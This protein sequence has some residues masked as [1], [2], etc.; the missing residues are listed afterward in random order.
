MKRGIDPSLGTLI[1]R[2]WVG[3]LALI[4]L[5]GILSL[6]LP[7]QPVSSAPLSNGITVEEISSSYTFAQQLSFS[8]HATANADIVRVYL[9][10]RATSDAQALPVPVEIEPT[11]DLSVTH[12]LDLRR[13]PLQPFATAIYWWHILDADGN[14][15][16]TEAQQFKYMDDRFQWQ[17]LSDDTGAGTT[18]HWIDGQGDIVFGQAALDIA[19][20][21]LKEIN[22][23]LRAPT[24]QPIDIYIYDGQPN[25]RAA[26]VLTGREWVGGQAHPELGIVV[27]AVPFE[28]GYTTRMKRDIPHEITHLLVYRTVTPESYVYVPEW[29][30]EGLATANE[31]SPRAEFAAA[32]EAARAQDQLLPLENLCV[33]FSPDPTVAMLSYAQSSS[34][35]KF[36]RKEYGASGIRDL[37]AAY[38]DGASC[39]AGVREALD[40]TLPR[41]EN[42][43]RA[44]LEPQA[45]WL[46]TLRQIDV[47]VGLWVL[48]LLLAV[49]MLGQLR[50]RSAAQKT[51][52]R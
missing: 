49:P 11:T 19:V 44:S 7:P 17:V 25:L 9:F 20:S 15:L 2:L 22:A 35:I 39:A 28:D 41:L 16:T 29:L 3:S 4:W 50:G 51:S 13:T 8:L 14:S 45:P 30:D 36:I 32:I 18:V 1:Y 37:L 38:R 12:T 47:W 43:W 26:M 34:L 48:S 27:I 6:F 21:S 5:L 33:P 42:A 31:R 23:E 24:D 46:A 10:L 40:I 52:R